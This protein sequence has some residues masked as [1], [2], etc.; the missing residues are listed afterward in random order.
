MARFFVDRPI[1]A[2]V[3]AIVV[4]L[5]GIFS[6]CT[7]P[8]AHYPEVAPPAV[9]IMATSP[10][11]SAQVLEETVTQVIEQKMSSLDRL[12]YMASTSASSGRATVTLTFESGT[13]P[14]IAQVQVQ[15]RLALATPLLPQE[16]QQQGLVV[17]K[18]SLNYLNVLAFASEDGSMNHADLSDY[19]GT[20]I[21]DHLG[22]I[23]GVSDVTLFGSKYAMR[24]WLNPHKL[25][26]FNLTPLDVRTAVEA[27]NT[28]ISAGQLGGLPA[29]EGQPLSATITAQ[30]RLRSAEEFRQILLR[31]LPDGS[32]VLLQDVARIELDKES[33][34]ASARYNGKPATGLGIK[35]AAGANA[36]DTVA[37]IDAKLKQ[38]ERFFPPG[39][40][41]YKPYDST[42]FVRNSIK[43]VVYTLGEAMVLVFLVMFLFLQ[44]LRATLIPLIAIPVVLLGT[45]GILA[46]AGFTL[47]TLT[48]FAMVLAIGLLVDDAIVV[49]ENVERVMMEERLTPK[50]ATLKSMGQISGALVAVAVVLSAV[51][52]PMAFFSGSTGIIY[53][54]FSLTI[55][56]AMTLSVLV[57]MIL[58]P[59]LCATLLKPGHGVPLFRQRGFFGWFN[60]R[61]ED[62]NGRYQGLVRHM[63]GKGWPY[64]AGY[65]LLLAVVVYGLIKLPAG[66]M[67]DEDQ[68]NLVSLI[69]LPPGATQARTLEVIQHAERYFMGEHQQSVDGIFAIAGFSFAGSDQNMGLMFIK[70]K[71]WEERPAKEQSVAYIAAKARHYFAKMRDARAFTFSQ[72]AVPDLGNASGFDLMLKDSTN[73]GHQALMQARNQLLDTLTQDPR[74]IIVRANGLED[75]PMFKLDIDANKAQAMGVSINDINRTLAI[76]W[77]SS[78]VNDF[79][80]RG[81]VKKVMLQ[82][83]AQYRMQP[84]DI[85]HW[86]VRN[87][88]GEMVAFDAFAKASWTL[89]SPRLERYNGMPAV[90]LLGMGMPGEASSGEALDIVERAVAQLPAGFSYEWTG[91]SWQEKA[92]AGQAGLLYTVSILMVFLCLAAL[93]ESWTIPVSVILVV[94]LGVFGAL[95]ATIIA[96]RMNDIYF[97]VGLLTTIGLTSKNAI[98]IVEF[99]KA[100]HDKGHDLV[101]AT[102]EGARM[103]LRPIMMT[104]L[105][106]VLGVLP[107]LY[108][109]GASAGAQLSLGLAVVGGMLSATLLVI[110]FVPLFFVLVC[111][112]ANR[113][114][115]PG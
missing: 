57:A 14:D 77:G 96:W 62:A 72:P 21:A 37:A 82:G 91:L 89:G 76:A 94:P 71:P 104:S 108:A 63:L 106:F 80:D 47:N 105:T 107:M 39:M 20:Y 75:A 42:P 6:L 95:M 87:D 78:Y 69:Q 13:D 58:T 19:V 90:E 66:F 8:V 98:L 35:L 24:I 99:A 50:Q 64:M 67:P 83:D 73:Q 15:N 59:A 4:M 52:I 110:F 46:V 97:Q 53:R 41:V 5:A 28:Q 86:Y 31:T 36:L 61:F 60:R 7:L 25:A 70:L 49:V 88:A 111:R 38:L 16:V 109:S 102:L 45:L 3:L 43:D 101:A 100:L 48:L 93:Y 56:S 17:S 65:A 12:S 33:Y 32:R 74:L 103:R 9:S 23:N 112:C 113:Q 34:D 51:F 10:G 22:R 92:A 68:G 1:F 11:A 30:S 29:L 81:W 26:S 85:D 2:W 40:K 114:R 44:N 79:I 84:D 115:Q 27:Q 54:Q 18:W 55:V